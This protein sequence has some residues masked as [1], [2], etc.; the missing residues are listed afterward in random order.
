MI[1]PSL[2][3]LAGIVLLGAGWTA[4]G[5][6][7]LPRELRR[8]PDRLA[9]GATSLA[10][11]CGLTAI[12]LTVL[13]MIGLSGRLSCW[14]V[15][16][17]SLP[18][19]AAGLRGLSQRRDAR[20]RALGARPGRD[21]WERVGLLLLAGLLLLTLF[22]TLAPPASMDATVYHLRAPREIMR[23]GFWVRPDEPHAYQPLYVEM[24]FGEALVFGGGPLA[25][26]VH[27]LLGVGAVGAAAAWGRRFGGRGVW[28][29]VIFAGTALYVWEATGSF[30]DL[31]LALFCSL[32]LFWAVRPEVSGSTV[33]AGLLAGFGAGSKFTGVVAAALIGLAAAAM[34]WPDRRAAARRIL[35]IG[36]LALLVA[37]PWYIRDFV[38]TGNPIYPVANGLFGLPPVTLSLLPYGCGR[39]LFHLI[40][41][42]VDVL[43]RS[44]AFD[45]GWSMG[46]AYLGFLRWP[47][48]SAVRARC[49]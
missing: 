28:A 32:A 11:G 44:D 10:L 38:L 39:D 1:A 49:R 20:A 29:A 3:R 6:M 47:S 36:A 46:P 43:L 7:V 12:A 22:V 4:T 19:A 9:V 42:P 40:S 17:S 14:V 27:W 30:I 35:I 48:R 23:G 13:A 24:L 2:L 33:M 31:G 15:G 26:L 18:A 37:A 45:Q 16:L 34:V 8:D 41:S 21:R 5:H 25:A